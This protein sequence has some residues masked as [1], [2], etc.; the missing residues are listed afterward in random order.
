[1]WLATQERFLWNK[2]IEL[3]SDDKLYYIKWRN[4]R[5]YIFQIGSPLSESNRISSSFGTSQ[6]KVKSF[7]LPLFEYRCDHFTHRSMLHPIIIIIMNNDNGNHVFIFE[8]FWMFSKMLL[9]IMSS[10]LM[11]NCILNAGKHACTLHS[12]HHL[13]RFAVP[14]NDDG[15]ADFVDEHNNSIHNMLFMMNYHY[16]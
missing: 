16:V 11:L 4:L 15:D 1:M 3:Q 8:F 13:L 14:A 10:L 9:S 6:R 5:A 12:T 7:L 2:K